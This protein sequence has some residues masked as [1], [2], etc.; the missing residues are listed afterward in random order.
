MTVWLDVA[1]IGYFHQQCI[2]EHG[3]LRG[4]A[5]EGL[6][7][8]TLAR[9]RDLL[10]YNPDAGLFELAASY[11]VGFARNHCFP[12]GNK[13]ISLISI[14]VFLQINGFELIAAEVDA[15]AVIRELASGELSEAELA[16]WIKN[17]SQAVDIGAD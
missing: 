15:V 17:N 4:D 10:N 13:R 14:D 2:D 1:D 5:T 16:L 11:G 3:G 8:S 9:P 6:P 7:E 12:D